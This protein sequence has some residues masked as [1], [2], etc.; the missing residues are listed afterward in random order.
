[1]MRG[2]VGSPRAPRVHGRRTP[3]GAHKRKAL[4]NGAE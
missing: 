2:R 1:M 4:D 3:L